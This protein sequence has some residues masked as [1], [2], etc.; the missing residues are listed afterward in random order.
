MQLYGPDGDRITSLALAIASNHPQR[1]PVPSTLRVTS[2][3]RGR[4]RD[5]SARE[6][7]SPRQP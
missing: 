6:A 3:A 4:H 2:D 1:S 5:R 7:G